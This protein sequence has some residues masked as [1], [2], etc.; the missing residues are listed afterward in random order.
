MCSL[1]RC[2]LGNCNIFNFLLIGSVPPVYKNAKQDF[3]H[4]GYNS[5]QASMNKNKVEPQQST[6]Y[7]QAIA[8]LQAMAGS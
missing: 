3:H 5:K 7:Q 2:D 6:L 4:D 8:S 1:T